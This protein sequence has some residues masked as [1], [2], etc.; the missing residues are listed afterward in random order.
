M[1]RSSDPD[2]IERYSADE[3]NTF[4]AQDVE[5]VVF[6]D[7]LAEARALLRPD[8]VVFVEGS[9]D[10][11]REEPSLRVSRIIPIEAARRELS[12]HL[13]VHLRTTGGRSELLPEL[14]DLCS[15]HRGK[16]P[17]L[18]QVSSPEGWVTTIKPKARGLTAVDPCNEL[19]EQLEAI[20]GT[21]S[22]LCAGPR[23]SVTASTME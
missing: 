6:P 2:V 20:V 1:R 4:F 9:V 10:R 3:S 5:A 11:R 15:S 18:L 16:C 7:Q 13:L 22:V 21:G 17:L 8:A 14:R 23:G 12:R 19:L